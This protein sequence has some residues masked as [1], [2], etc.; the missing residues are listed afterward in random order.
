MDID[1]ILGE[2]RRRSDADGISDAIASL[3]DDVAE[4]FLQRL[5]GWSSSTLAA[6]E[7]CESPIE[8]ILA[9]YLDDLQGAFLRV[10]RESVIIC[11]QCEV[12]T[13]SG[14]YRADFVVA[15]SVNGHQFSIVVECDGHDFHEKTKM[16]A[17]RDKQRDRAMAVA[18]FHVLRFTG[19]EIV[20]DP[21]RCATDVGDLI[22]T[23]AYG[24]GV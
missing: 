22:F 18:G 11:P 9:L 1:W 4:H 13:P 12:F 10:K 20:R 15:C 2:L 3:P 5:S 8:Q 6:L 17:A 24:K 23:L 14:R 21:F 19:S 16:Q 7:S